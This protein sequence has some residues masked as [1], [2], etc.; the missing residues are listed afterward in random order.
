MFLSGHPGGGPDGSG[1]GGAGAGAGGRGGG[2]GTGGGT[3][4]MV[5]NF[6]K[7]SFN[8]PPKMQPQLAR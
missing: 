6:N 4:L 7:V 1:T 3:G 2:A 8:A 5:Y